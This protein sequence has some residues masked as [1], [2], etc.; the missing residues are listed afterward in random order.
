MTVPEQL[1]EVGHFCPPCLLPMW[2]VRL[3]GK[4]HHPLSHLTRLLLLVLEPNSASERGQ[5]IRKFVFTGA[6]LAPDFYLWLMTLATR[7]AYSQG[8]P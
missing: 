3:D 2:V 7:E 1:T 5:H 8:I 6:V 4:H